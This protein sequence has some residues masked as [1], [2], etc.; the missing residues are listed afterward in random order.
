MI[1]PCALGRTSVCVGRMT[2]EPP[3]ASIEDWRSVLHNEGKCMHTMTRWHWQSFLESGGW[4]PEF[5]LSS[6]GVE[7]HLEP[8]FSVGVL[9]LSSYSVLVYDDLVGGMEIIL[10]S[11]P[12]SHG[13]LASHP[14][15]NQRASLFRDI[16]AFI[17]ICWTLL[18][19]G[20]QDSRWIDLEIY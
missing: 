14:K 1:L 12:V 7:R 20:Y 10:L 16:H 19:T 18:V 3:G 4:W 15:H 11:A 2:A 6:Q 17:P 13:M 8:L 5:S 9:W